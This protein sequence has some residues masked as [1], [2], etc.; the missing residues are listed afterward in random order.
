MK[1]YITLI[2]LCLSTFSYGQ[3]PSP[4]SYALDS[5]QKIDDFPILYPNCTQLYMGVAGTDIVNLNGLTNITTINGLFVSNTSLTNFNG[6]ENVTT[7]N[8]GDIT[9]ED[10]DLLTNMDALNNMT[11]TACAL[12][13]FIENNPL[14]ESLQPLGGLEIS[15]F[16]GCFDTISWGG[17]NNNDSLINLEGLGNFSVPNYFT[18]SG[19]ASL[20]SFQGFDTSFKIGGA[21]EPGQTNS[22]VFRVE[23]NSSLIAI[24]NLNDVVVV[25]GGWIAINNNPL[26]ENLMMDGTVEGGNHTVNI[27]NNPNLDVCSG[28][29]ICKLAELSTQA[30]PKAILQIWENDTCCENGAVVIKKCLLGVS[31]AFLQALITVFPN[32]VSEIL[33]IETDSSSSFVSANVRSLLGELVTTSQSSVIDMSKLASGIY[34]IEV[35]T[36]KGTLVKKIVKE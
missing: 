35:V 6:L 36:D 5:Q 7:M 13:F 30:P 29:L 3:C 18:V 33:T 25:Q 1:F 31:D 12:Y 21:G 19:N 10:N 23:N 24:D 32:P 16:A 17:I 28:G 20:E 26:L 9:I 4:G 8:D 15:N 14:L 22:G 27:T 11:G 2:I 34:F